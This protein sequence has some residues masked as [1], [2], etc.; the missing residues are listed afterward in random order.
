MIYKHANYNIGKSIP[1]KEDVSIA[2]ISILLYFLGLLRVL[3]ARLV[4]YLRPRPR[5][6][7]W[8]DDNKILSEVPLTKSLLSLTMNCKTPS[9]AIIEEILVDLFPIQL[10]SSNNSW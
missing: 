4:K 10:C 1:T 5:T 3:F 8:W 2:C 6:K 7:L 9:S